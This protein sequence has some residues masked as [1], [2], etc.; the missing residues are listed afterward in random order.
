[1]SLDREGRIT[2]ANK[3]ACSILATPPRNLVGHF[4][5]ALLPADMAG[6]ARAMFSRFQLR[7]LSRWQR[8]ITL[9]IGGQTRRILVNAVGLIT[10]EGQSRGIVAVFN[11]VSE[12]ERMQRVAAWREVARRIAH[13]IK[14][15][16]TPIKL[17]AQRLQRKF[18]D[19]TDD[20]VFGQST[21][22]IVREVEA[23][24][25]MVQEFS[26]FAKLPEVNPAPGDILPL[27]RETTEL[28]RTSHPHITWECS[29][30][31]ALPVLPLD[32]QALHRV[33]MNIFANATEAVADRGDN[34]AP[35]NDAPAPVIR[36]RA[37][38]DQELG[39]VRID[40]EDNGRGLSDVEHSRLFE[41]Y[42]SQKKD[43]TGLGLTIVKSI[44]NDHKGYVRAGVSPLGGAGII[45][46]LP[47]V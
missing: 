12:Q 39:L 30:P 40:I 5:P 46:D 23:L 25:E 38:A 19:S 42:F 33:F 13:E 37:A 8:E 14:N 6:D 9:T 47:F 31:D 11:D 7:P 45:I 1:M 36:V 35:D 16:L 20:P 15:P 29:L 10:P 2:M 22:L 17:S 21:S 44:I 43:G 34:A 28:F 24:Q 32:K 3:A 26:A 41:P 18:G 4:L 27:L